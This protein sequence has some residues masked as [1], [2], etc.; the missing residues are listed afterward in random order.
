MTSL[1][2]KFQELLKDRAFRLW[3]MILAP[4]FFLAVVWLR[5]YLEMTVFSATDRFS[6]YTGLHHICWYSSTMLAIVLVVHLV[7]RRPVER[8]ILFLYGVVIVVIPL[9]WS[10]VSGI[11]LDLQYLNGTPREILIQIGTLSISEPRNWPL[12]PELILI[13]F[14]MGVVGRILSGSWVRGALLSSATTISLA[15]FGLT[16]F[17]LAGGKIA[18]LTFASRLIRGQALQ[19]TAWLVVATSLVG[20]LLWRHGLFS[21][22]RRSWTIAAVIAT[23]VWLLWVIVVLGTGWFPSSFDAVSTGLFPASTT[24]VVVRFVRSDRSLVTPA[25]WGLLALVLT[26]QAA[27]LMPIILHRESELYRPKSFNIRNPNRRGHDLRSMVPGILQ[28]TP[29][30]QKVEA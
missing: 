23:E 6:Y 9:G 11:P 7:L 25:I 21:H 26:L 2:V 29:T 13:I 15:V 18:V 27:T 17:G 19:A 10:L 28:S 14:G 22:G 3:L 5:S 8:A 1:A 16:W 12:V 20:V 24:L 30:P 4:P